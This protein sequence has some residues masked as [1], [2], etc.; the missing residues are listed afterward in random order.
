M[1]AAVASVTAAG[2]PIG[3]SPPRCGLVVYALLHAGRFT[4]VPAGV[5]PSSP[6]GSRVTDPAR[7]PTLSPRA[8]PAAAGRATVER[9]RRQVDAL[10]LMRVGGV[11]G[12]RLAVGWCGV[13]NP[14]A[15]VSSDASPAGERPG[16]HVL[17]RSQHPPRPG[18]SPHGTCPV[19]A[20]IPPI[21]DRGRL[22]RCRGTPQ[23]APDH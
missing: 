18:A 12:L 10:G 3:L 2:L 17:A 1:R 19:R 6:P 13:I 15:T 11:V 23:H 7:G 21:S 16:D 20:H 5:M 14:P 4:Q 8:L 9:G 22:V